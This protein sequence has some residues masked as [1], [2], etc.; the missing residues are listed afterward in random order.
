MQGDIFCKKWDKFR[1]LGA[2]LFPG[3]EHFSVP[4]RGH[5]TVAPERLEKARP[6]GFEPVTLGSEERGKIRLCF[7]LSFF[8]PKVCGKY[9]GIFTFSDTGRSRKKRE[10][11]M[12]QITSPLHRMKGSIPP[13]QLQNLIEL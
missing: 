8:V 10:N 2:T 1:H 4:D 13:Y 6:T 11:L 12:S 9:A 7:S 5:A 3:K